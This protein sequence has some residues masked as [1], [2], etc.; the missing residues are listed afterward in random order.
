MYMQCTINKYNQNH[1]ILENLYDAY[2]NTVSKENSKII[3]TY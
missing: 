1:S 3:N 2:N